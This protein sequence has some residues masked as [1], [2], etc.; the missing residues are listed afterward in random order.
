VGPPHYGMLDDRVQECVLAAC[1]CCNCLASDSVEG[2]ALLRVL[3][4][5]ARWIP[6]AN[7]LA[8]TLLTLADAV[9]SSSL[10]KATVVRKS[11]EREPVGGSTHSAGGPYYLILF[12]LLLPRSHVPC[13]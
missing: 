1:L 10:G 5:A 11:F 3:D 7:I 13:S 9:E 8:L 6:E 4:A 2:V 12:S